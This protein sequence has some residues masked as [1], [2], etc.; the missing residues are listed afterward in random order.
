MEHEAQPTK[1][2]LKIHQHPAGSLV[3]ALVQTHLGILQDLA[4]VV[5]GYS[6]A[7]AERGSHQSSRLQAQGLDVACTTSKVYDAPK[8]DDIC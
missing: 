5:K 2:L 3:L 1:H 7:S 4:D 8:F 6:A